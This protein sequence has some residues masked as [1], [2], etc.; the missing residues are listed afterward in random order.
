MSSEF[1]AVNL[2]DPSEAQKKAWQ[3]D[4]FL[5]VR[6]FFS[7][8]ETA[9]L[10]R[11]T[12]EITNAPEVPGRHMV[13]YETSRTEP[14]KRVI[15][16]IENFCPFHA[17]FDRVV[18]NGRL[19]LWLDKLMGGPTVLFKE[20]INF[21]LP[22]SAGFEPHQDQQAGWSRYAPLF[23]TALVTLDPATL[24][25]GCL[26]L[27]P[28]KHRQGLI[29]EEWTPLSWDDLG[30]EP[31]ETAPGDVVFFDSFVPHASKPNQTN[32]PR[33]ILYLTYNRAD[34]GDHRVQYFADK[35]REFPPD[36]ERDGKT[37]YTFRV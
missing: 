37:D 27:V 36:V 15:Q 31:V 29:G 35:R 8:R 18:R 14:D 23:V 30:L 33:R 21:K 20:K 17:E 2:A 3:H 28:G 9:D 34:H 32:A 1:S 11:W 22:G 16:R 6:N 10:L 13:Y 25:N 5:I 24:A 4:G 12:D 26:E 19:S 7:A